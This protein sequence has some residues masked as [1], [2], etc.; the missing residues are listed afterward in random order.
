MLSSLPSLTPIL[1]L[2]EEA[3]TRWPDL[4]P[5]PTAAEVQCAWL[6]WCQ[7]HEVTTPLAESC[8]CQVAG[9][10]TMAE[11]VDPE[12]NE[13]TVVME[14]DQGG[15]SPCAAIYAVEN[16]TACVFVKTPPAGLIVGTARKT[17]VPNTARDFCVPT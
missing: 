10:A 17:P 12:T 1:K 6:C 5:E 9:F 16:I 7:A 2:G 14:P 13:P 11:C 4:A 15:L 8:P 3:R